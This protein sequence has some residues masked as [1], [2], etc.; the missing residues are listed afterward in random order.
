MAR[1][2]PAAP[3]RLWAAVALALAPMGLPSSAA[4][5]VVAA[6]V[7]SRGPR[8]FE[9]GVA[10]QVTL[11][12]QS[13]L[14]VLLGIGVAA[15]VLAAA[16]DVSRRV[17]HVALGALAAALVMAVSARLRD[18]TILLAAALLLA[19]PLVGRPRRRADGGALAS[20]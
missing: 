11:V 16:G 5:R 8:A 6:D 17:V 12:S 13:P 14:R 3:L 10:G 20:S 19:A 4:Y 7:A 15:L 1:R 18:V 9:G 2:P